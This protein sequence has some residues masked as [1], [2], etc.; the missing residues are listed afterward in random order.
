M[1]NVSS[2][3]TR[4]YLFR[5]WRLWPSDRFYLGTDLKDPMQKCFEDIL[6]AS[7]EQRWARRLFN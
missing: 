6:A 4:G 7:I 3:I 5:Q 1:E 2:K